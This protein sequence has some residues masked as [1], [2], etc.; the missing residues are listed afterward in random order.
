MKFVS[1]SRTT[2]K[3]KAV[4]IHRVG[5]NHHVISSFMGIFSKAKNSKNKKWMQVLNEFWKTIKDVPLEQENEKAWHSLG[6]LIHHH[7]SRDWKNNDCEREIL[8][9]YLYPNSAMYTDMDY[10]KDLSFEFLEYK[11]YFENEFGVNEE[12]DARK[13]WEEEEW[14]ERFNSNCLDRW[15]R[16]G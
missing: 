3:T 4:P 11:N 15:Y 16:L 2:K 1:Q 10:P 7:L 12:D 13:E 8:S 5:L 14:R 9:A 6:V